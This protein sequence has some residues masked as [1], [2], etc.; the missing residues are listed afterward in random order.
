MAMLS[1]IIPRIEE[2]IGD[3]EKT[4]EV[5]ALISEAEHEKKSLRFQ[6]QVEGIAAAKERGVQFG[7]PLMDFPKNFSKICKKQQEGML[8]VTEASRALNI[9]RQQFYRLRK[10]YEMQEPE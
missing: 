4:A 8:T 3:K 1:E 6:K 9:S 10:R 7:R 2:I 5:L